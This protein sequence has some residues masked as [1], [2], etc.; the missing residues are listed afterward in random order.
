MSQCTCF[1]HDDSFYIFK[2]SKAR[3]PLNKIPCLEPLPI[4]EK[5]ASGTLNTK[6][7]GQ[8]ITKKSKLYKSNVPNHL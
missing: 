7:Q 8:L 4:P 5:K 1:I 3:P 6:A 2:A